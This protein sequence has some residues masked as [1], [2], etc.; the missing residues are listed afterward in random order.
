[1]WEEWD[2]YK[3]EIGFQ[4]GETRNINL[5]SINIFRILDVIFNDLEI[6]LK[7]N[8]ISHHCDT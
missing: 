2:I 1:M 5:E 3:F 4:L 7:R 8:F 6:Q